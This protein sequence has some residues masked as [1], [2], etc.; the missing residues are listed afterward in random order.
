MKIEPDETLLVTGG[1]DG[2][3]RIH[4]SDTGAVV[5]TFEEQPDFLHA[6]AWSADGA[7]IATGCD[8]GRITLIDAA[9]RK[10][11]VMAT[12]GSKGAAP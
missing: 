6:V 4:A 11:A 7:W 12:G 5:H 8:T 10:R 9:K 2:R 3:A 1:T